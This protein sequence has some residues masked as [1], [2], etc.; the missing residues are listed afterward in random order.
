MNQNESA[1][2]DE[3]SEQTSRDIHNELLWFRMRNLAIFVTGPTFAGNE[4][5]KKKKSRWE[6]IDEARGFVIILVVYCIQFGS[7][8][9]SE[10]TV[11]EYK[12]VI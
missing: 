6:V 1:H 4:R 7:S 5:D 11:G 12:L 8:K 9:I 3:K 2:S 10:S